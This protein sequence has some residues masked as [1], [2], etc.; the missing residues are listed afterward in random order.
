MSQFNLTCDI[1]SHI[2]K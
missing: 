2:G 1:C